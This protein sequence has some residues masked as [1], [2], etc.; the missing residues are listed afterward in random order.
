MAPECVEVE[1]FPGS[2]SFRESEALHL[3]D[4][5]S[6]RLRGAGGFI[7]EEKVSGRVLGIFAIAS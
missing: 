4:W 2:E 7:Y 5:A 6:C 1:G 3:G